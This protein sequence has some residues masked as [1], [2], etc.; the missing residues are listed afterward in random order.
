M[1]EHTDRPEGDQITAPPLDDLAEEGVPQAPEDPRWARGRLA[2]DPDFESTST[3]SLFD[4]DEGWLDLAQ[5][6]ALVA[7]LKQRFISAQTHP[8]EWKAIAT[9]PGPIRA[10][11]HDMFL[12]LHLDTEREVAFKKQVTPEGGGTPFPT[13]LYDA[14]WG[15]EDTLVLVFL[16]TRYR[17]EQAAGADRVFVDK[18]DIVEYVSQY[19]PEHA[20]DVVGDTR[21]TL[22]AIETV[23]KTGLLIGPA[24]GDRFQVSNAIEP[25]LPLET[26]QTLLDWLR[27]QNTAPART[28]DPTADDA[29]PA[30]M[31]AT[32]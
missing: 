2:E 26:L 31:E 20:N 7:L 30:E 6:R 23:Y 24:T 5:R 25:L 1:T 11:L 8:R 14:A 17:S 27:A 32:R 28:Q 18:D 10:R 13:L 9:N 15:R 3:L 29:D 16:R 4:G 21:R 22:K 19:R 12:D